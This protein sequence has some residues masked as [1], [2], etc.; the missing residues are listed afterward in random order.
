MGISANGTGFPDF[1]ACSGFRACSLES[2]SA[3]TLASFSRLSAAARS[4]FSA[5]ALSLASFSSRS[6]FFVSSRFFFSR[7]FCSRCLRSCSACCSLASCRRRCFSASFR[8]RSSSCTFFRP[9]FS[10]AAPPS[11][12]AVRPISFP[13]PHEWRLPRQPSWLPVVPFLL[14]A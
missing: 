14:L 4:L 1:A 10:S 12:V 13:P 2:F 6:R 9:P 11:S 5:A 7:S 3:W 8:C